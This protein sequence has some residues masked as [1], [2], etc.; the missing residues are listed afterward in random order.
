MDVNID[1]H[2]VIMQLD[3]GA[4]VSIIPDTIYN[5]YLTGWC[6]TERKPLRNYS[7]NELDLLGK[8]EVPVMYESQ[9]MTLPLVAVRGYKVPLLERN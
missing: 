8:L 3:T 4:A 2:N 5:K 6:F 7:G 9:T 1:G